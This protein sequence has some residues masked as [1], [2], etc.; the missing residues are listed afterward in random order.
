[1]EVQMDGQKDGLTGGWIDRRMEVQI[2]KRNVTMVSVLKFQTH[3][4][5]DFK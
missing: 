3:S 1:M 5:S 2:G 4:L